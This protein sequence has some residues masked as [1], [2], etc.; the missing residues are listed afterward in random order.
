MANYCN[1][2]F[3]SLS[4]SDQRQ[5]AGVYVAGLLYGEGKRTIR[6]MLGEH[7]PDRFAQS[8]QQIV[9]QSPWESQPVLQAIAGQLSRTSSTVALTVDEVMFVKHGPHSAGVE[10]QYSELTG[11]VSNCQLA[12]AACLVSDE[13]AVPINW[14]LMLPPSWD[15]DPDRRK[16]ARVP[17][18]ERH[19]P[20]W[21][22]LVAAIDQIADTWP[23]PNAPLV[24]DAVTDAQVDKVLMAAE[25]RGQ[26]YAVEVRG[27]LRDL[28]HV[29]HLTPTGGPG[30]SSTPAPWRPMTLAAVAR[31]AEDRRQTATWRPPGAAPK[32]GQFIA[33]PVSPAGTGEL[34]R[35]RPVCRRLLI[36]EWPLALR[37]PRRYWLT[38]MVDRPLTELVPLVKLT[39]RSRAAIEEMQRHYGLCDYEGRSYVGWR[40]HVTLSSAAYA[41]SILEARHREDGPCLLPDRLPSAGRTA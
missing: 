27:D 40:H 10:R 37:E 11:R 18:G 2:V 23:V 7:A 16:R 35:Q 19:L 9:S 17:R 32:R 3:R 36:A 22:H 33:V 34:D 6:R 25:S 8:L 29:P 24:T 31:L 28:L 15:E 39:L 14:R 20:R 30:R 38:N 41:F 26:Q 12:I 5:W 21:H 4:R 13:D 1:N